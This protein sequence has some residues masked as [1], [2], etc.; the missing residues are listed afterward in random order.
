[1]ADERMFSCNCFFYFCVLSHFEKDNFQKLHSRID[2][3]VTKKKFV[4]SRH[5]LCSN[6]CCSFVNKRRSIWTLREINPNDNY[7]ASYVVCT[8]YAY[9]IL[10]EIFI[11]EYD[12][13]KMNLNCQRRNAAVQ[14]IGTFPCCYNYFRSKQIDLDW[15]CVACKLFLCFLKDFKLNEIKIIT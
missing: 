15:F 14:S 2:D 5:C 3:L 10:S 8:N 6:C 13:K 11:C 7:N 1:M 9:F 12:E 4:K